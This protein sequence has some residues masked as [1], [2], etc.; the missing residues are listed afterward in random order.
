[1]I[2]KSICIKIFSSLFNIKNIAISKD[3]FISIIKVYCVVKTYQ[4]PGLNF[5]WVKELFVLTYLL[6]LW[7]LFIVSCKTFKVWSVVIEV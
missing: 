6:P 2:T 1:M 7:F 5:N 3:I 4:S